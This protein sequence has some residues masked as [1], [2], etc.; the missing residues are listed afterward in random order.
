MKAGP[1]DELPEDGRVD[2]IG[3]KSN[4]EY[5]SESNGKDLHNSIDKSDDEYYSESNC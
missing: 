5:E 3:D 1:T 4:D 2:D